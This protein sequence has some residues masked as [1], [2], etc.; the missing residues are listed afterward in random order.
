MGATKIHAVEVNGKQ[1][2]DMGGTGLIESTSSSSMV[3]GFKP[4]TLF[5]SVASYASQMTVVGDENKNGVATTHLTA[6]ASL[7][8]SAA[9]P[10]GSAFGLT[11]GTWTMDVWIAKDGGYAVS[12][13]IAG[14]GASSSLSMSMD[15]S[16]VNAPANVVKGP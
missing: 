4:E 3:D 7:L 11:D 13:V 12:Y 2:V 1:Y 14:K 5:G 6:P 8:A 15:L 10:L 9:A 16:N